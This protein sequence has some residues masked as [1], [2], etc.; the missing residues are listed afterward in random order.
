[1]NEYKVSCIVAIYNSKYFL[2]KLITSIIKQTYSNIEVILIDDGSPDNSGAICDRYAVDDK[3]IKVIHKKNGGVCEARNF[4]LQVATGDYVMIIDGDDWL[5][6]DCVEYMMELI[7]RTDSDMAFSDIVF[8]TR[9]RKQTE[10]DYIE[11]WSA[12]KAAV[13]IIYPYM[14]LGP[15]NKIYSSKLLRDNNISFSVPWFGEGLCFAVT[16]AQHSNHVGVGHRKVY[17]Y[18][19]NNAKSGLTNYKVKNGLN[20]IQNIYTIRDS[21]HIKTAYLEKAAEWHIWKNYTFLLLQIVGADEVEKYKEEYSKCIQYIRK[22]FITVMMNSDISRRE[23]MKVLVCGI[24]PLTYTKMIID[25]R[26]KK[27]KKD[28]MGDMEFKKS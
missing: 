8:T 2:D 7:Q 11:T 19:L 20:A 26:V 4:G 18:R 12:E 22:N 1:M 6:L 28:L 17:N 16:A 14:A 13:M 21:L 27:L 15:W 9:D 5:E 25:W 3:R 23:K 24:A 10:K